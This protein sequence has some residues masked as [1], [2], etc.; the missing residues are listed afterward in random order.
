[1]IMFGGQEKKIMKRKD[2]LHTIVMTFLGAVNG[3][4]V[5]EVGSLDVNGSVRKAVLERK[6]SGYIGVDM[7]EGPG[8]DL[9]CNIYDLEKVFGPGSVDVVLCLE[10]LEHVEDWKTGIHNLKVIAKAGGELIISVPTKDFHYHPYPEDY[11]R[12]SYKDLLHIFSDME[13][14]EIA[15]ITNGLILKVRKP[16][17]FN[18]VDLTNYEVHHVDRR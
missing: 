2:K 9:I 16:K 4:S 3:K 5:V 14:V 8:V 10:T 7:R 17:K 18:E 12:F 1:M 15:R 11:W 13:F 6:P